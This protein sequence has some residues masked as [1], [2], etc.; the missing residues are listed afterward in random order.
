MTR[1]KIMQLAIKQFD[2]LTKKE[3]YAILKFR[4][5][6]FIVEQKCFYLDLDD[7]DQSAIHFLT[8]EQEKLIA[9]SRVNIDSLNKIAKIQRVCV[10]KDYRK[11]QL[12][13]QLITGILEYLNA[14]A[15]ILS[16][17]LN[18]QSHLQHFYEK[19]GFKMI[20][21]PFDDAGILH[22]KMIK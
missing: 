15:D 21:K 5:E 9:Y 19:Q 6:I 11:H 18:A 20:G 22:V 10:D 7:K 2:E 14:T 4:M 13:S 8:T 12:G 16:V 17:E 1:G 3:L